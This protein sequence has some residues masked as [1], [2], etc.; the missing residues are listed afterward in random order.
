[1]KIL[2][3]KTA[4]NISD[5]LIILFLAF[6]FF[7]AMHLSTAIT[8]EANMGPP[9]PVGDNSGIVFTRHDAIQVDSQV[10]DIEFI[11][12]SRAY[13]TAT[14]T[15]TNSSNKAVSV[16]SMFLSPVYYM[17]WQD[18]AREYTIKAGG[19]PLDYIVEVFFYEGQNVG[20]ADALLN[21]QEI[22]ANNPSIEEIEKEYSWMLDYYFL[23]AVT[24]E[25]DFLPNQTQDVVVRYLYTSYFNH[26]RNVRVLRYLL[27]P[28]R[29]WKYYGDLTINISLY[30]GHIVSS[31]L[32]L[33]R[34]S[35][36]VYVY[37]SNGLPSNELRIEISPMPR[38]FVFLRSGSPTLFI[39]FILLTVVLAV[40]LVFVVILLIKKRLQKKITIASFVWWLVFLFFSALGITFISLLVFSIFLSGFHWIIA[41]WLII[42]ICFLGFSGL[43]LIPT[44]IVNKRNKNT[45]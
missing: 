4:K 10:L 8:V 16:Q 26:W 20:G 38:G 32:D 37:N 36:R 31:T 14:Y 2:Q 15:M 9:P 30:E 25:I 5:F 33:V 35:R 34:Q 42:S 6:A 13:I 22:L 44:L 3:N 28:A 29:Y 11:S 18:N 17:R 45:A 39:L 21:W 40:A 23:S 12:P 24:F 19:N 7:G 27:T 1:M 41:I 43:L